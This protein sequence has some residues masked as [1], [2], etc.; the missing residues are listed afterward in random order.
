VGSNGRDLVFTSVSLE[1]APGL[2]D[3]HVQEGATQG[4]TRSHGFFYK[5]QADGTGIL[6]LPVRRGD[7]DGW[8][9]LVDGSAHVLFLRV[10]ANRF[11]RAGAL[12][13]EQRGAVNDRCIASCVDWYGNARPIFYRGRIFALLGYELVEGRL[14]DGAIAEVG[15]T[16]FL[17]PRAL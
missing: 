17:H 3:R 14:T 12:Q 13:S 1:G 2:V 15:R 11:T 9:H 6:G 8:E 5:P 16:T 4:E 10:N 7:S